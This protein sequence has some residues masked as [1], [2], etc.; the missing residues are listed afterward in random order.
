MRFLV[1]SCFLLMLHPLFAT[2]TVPLPASAATIEAGGGTEPAT[3]DVE[4][5]E[6][7]TP[8]GGLAA[9]SA[10]HSHRIL[11]NFGHIASSS[12]KEILAEIAGFFV[13]V[14]AGIVGGG[15]F[16]F[17]TGIL[18]YL[19]LRKRGFFKSPWRWMFLFNW[20]WPLV[21]IVGF[22]LSGLI[23]LPSIVGSVDAISTL[24]S[25]RPIERMAS[26]IYVAIAL[27]DAGHQLDGTESSAE[28]AAL[29]T[30]YEAVREV[31]DQKIT[32]AVNKV[33][34]GMIRKGEVDGWLDRV[35]HW[36]LRQGVEWVIDFT[37]DKESKLTWIAD[38]GLLALEDMSPEAF[39]AF[40]ADNGDA[41][42]RLADVREHFEVIRNA[43]RVQ[44]IILMVQNILV[45][46]AVGPV[47]I[48]LVL[49]IFRICVR[50]SETVE[51][52]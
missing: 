40:A 1:L 26:S 24:R 41:A 31:D 44:V 2:D 42:A 3:G 6:T 17:M 48:F 28:L 35:K 21:F 32:D 47:P 20:L 27:D 50:K 23:A 43:I 49:W 9:V 33:I 22:T 18:L 29:L 15:I 10:D 8:D 7:E 16:G 13:I 30:K 11:K 52:L 34:G 39:E 4:Q 45:A 19:L 51:E 37:I 12:T 25:K 38:V 5:S 46:L 36:M 14:I